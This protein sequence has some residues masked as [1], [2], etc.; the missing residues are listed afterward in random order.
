[1]LKEFNLVIDFGD[2]KEGLRYFWDE[3]VVNVF[4][5]FLIDF[6][7]LLIAVGA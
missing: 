1:M 6:Y 2:F 4:E 5:G 7:L 3:L